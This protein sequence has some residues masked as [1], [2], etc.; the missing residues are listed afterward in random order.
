MD[1]GKTIMNQ[2]FKNLNC[3]LQGFLQLQV[4]CIVLSFAEIGVTSYIW[5]GRDSPKLLYSQFRA[6]GGVQDTE[7]DQSE[8]EEEQEWREDLQEQHPVSDSSSGLYKIDLTQVEVTE[9][10]ETFKTFII[11]NQNFDFDH[12]F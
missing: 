3:G 4:I 1:R 5:L 9:F 10:Y 12:E 11:L 6:W 7:S 8:V 2:E